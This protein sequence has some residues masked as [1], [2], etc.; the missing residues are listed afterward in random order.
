[1]KP[2]GGKQKGSE[3]ERR[4]CK[5]LSLWL[6]KEKREDLFWR[7]AMSGGRATVARKRG[8]KLKAQAGDIS[9]VEAISSKFINQFYIECKDIG[10]LYINLAVLKRKGFLIDLIIDT[11]DK[12]QDHGKEYILIAKELRSPTV[13]I[14]DPYCINTLFDLN[15]S[16]HRKLRNKAECCTLGA[17]GITGTTIYLFDEFLE[18][19]PPD[20][21]L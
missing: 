20:A 10:K 17:Q 18:I 13:L 1:M 12:A 19:C 2:G 7:S 3:Y 9:S 21:F 15:S 16:Q 14:I 11:R 8:K 4:I 5:Q 6:S